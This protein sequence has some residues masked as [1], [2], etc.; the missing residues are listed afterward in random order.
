MNYEERCME[1]LKDLGDNFSHDR[2]GD[3][4][5]ALGRGISRAAGLINSHERMHEVVNDLCDAIVADACDFHTSF[6]KLNKRAAMDAE[7]FLRD[8]FNPEKPNA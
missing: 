6:H 3:L 4:F 8:V 7:K 5:V 2:L 1:M